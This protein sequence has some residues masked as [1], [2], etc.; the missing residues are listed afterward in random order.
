MAASKWSKM[1]STTEKLPACNDIIATCKKMHANI[2]QFFSDASSSGMHEARDLLFTSHAYLFFTHDMLYVQ[3]KK[4]N[5]R[6][7][8]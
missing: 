3:E 4:R 6:K 8:N 7:N 2:R 5:K 1:C